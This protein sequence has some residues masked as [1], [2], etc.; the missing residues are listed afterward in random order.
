MS[1]PN[2]DAQYSLNM[3]TK[4]LHDLHLDEEVLFSI[5][6]TVTR[7]WAETTS[8]NRVHGMNLIFVDKYDNRKHCW[9]P[10]ECLNTVANRLTEGNSYIVNKFSVQPFLQNDRCFDDELHLVLNDNSIVTPIHS[11]SA[12][13]PKDVF[14][15]TNMRNLSN[16]ASEITY[17]IDVVGIIEDLKPLETVDG[18]SLYEK[19]FY[20]QFYL[21]DLIHR[22]RVRFWDGFALQFQNILRNK[23]NNPPILTISS[24]KVIKNEYT[25]EI[26]MRN[27]KATRLF[28]NYH[29]DVETN[30]R[31]R[32]RAQAVWKGITRETKE[33]RGLNI[34]FVDDSRS[35]I[36]GFIAAKLAP[37]FEKEIMEGDIYQLTNFLVQDYTGLE[38]NRCVRFEKHIYFSHYTKME[39]CTSTALS[40][41]KMVVDLFPLNDLRSMEEDKRFLCVKDAQDLRDYVN[42]NDEQ[43]Q[44]KKFTLTDGS[45]DVSVTLFDDF[46]KQF[47]EAIKNLGSG[48]KFVIISS[49]KIGKFQG[50]VNLTNYPA[51]RFYINPDHHAVRKLQKRAENNNFL[52]EKEVIPTP[53]DIVAIDDMSI[54]DIKNMNKEGK[55]GCKVTVKKIK[56]D[57]NWFCYM[58]TK[59]NL[60]LDVIDGRYKCS[61]CGRFFPWPQKRFRLFVLCTDKTGALP[62]VLGDREIRR[63]TGKMVFDVELDL[64]EEEDGKFP[65]VLKNMLNKEYGF[66]ILVNEENILKNSEVYEVCDVQINVDESDENA[67]DVQ[68]ISEDAEDDQILDEMHVETE[69]SRNKPKKMAKKK[70]EEKINAGGGK[71]KQQT[72]ATKEKIIK[73]KKEKNP[74]QEK[75]KVNAN[76]QSKNLPK[77]KARKLIEVV[78]ESDD[79]DMT[80]NSYQLK[81]KKYGKT[82]FNL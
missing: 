45:T 36:H 38:F 82:N 5:E 11:S 19:H 43:K 10:V 30:L 31:K 55:V 50:D 79:E 71:P 57:L 22:I 52:A 7:K 23:V 12:G 20:H 81:N 61:E 62:L 14:H 64:T 47:E 77:K 33:F 72:S 66:T 15:F 51:T 70:Q 27:V 58:C 46:A 6:V 39:R 9:V 35:R 2:K 34:L 40:I 76:M 8:D 21:T 37:L 69:T 18:P 3:E 78:S 41:P 44:Q 63:L 73:I 26:T 16:P 56:E 67:A 17:L 54:A 49:A 25:G 4:Y 65:P 75:T 42:D 74:S 24:C 53:V 60:E 59:C 32:A 13:I 1:S 68:Q 29:S 28:I 80:L 48:N